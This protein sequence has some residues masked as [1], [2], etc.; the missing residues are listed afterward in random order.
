MIVFRDVHKGFGENHVLQ[1][2]SLEVREGETMVVLG[3]SGTGKSVALKHIV[4]LLDPD[5]GEVEVDGRIVHL[6][7]RNGLT[8]LRAR[9]GYVFQFSALFDSM[10]VEENISLGLKRQRLAPAEIRDRVTTSLSVVDLDGAEDRYPAEL[11]GGM[12]KRVGSFEFFKGLRLFYNFKD[13]WFGLV[14]SVSFGFVIALIGCLKGL[15]AA[16]GAEGVGRAA[17]EAVVAGAAMI[18]VLDAFWAVVLL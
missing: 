3:Y 11:S 13:V 2:F 17:T 5:S 16:G 7:D 12:R 15:G 6:L 4:G 9:V 10:T 18:L 14:K 8:D 1:G